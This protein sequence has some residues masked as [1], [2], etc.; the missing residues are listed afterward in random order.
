MAIPQL[1]GSTST[2]A[3]PQ[4]FKMLLRNFNSAIPQSQLILKSATLN[5]QLESFTSVIFGIFLAR[6]SS[7]FK[8]KIEVRK[9]CATVPL[10]KFFV[11]QRN[12]QF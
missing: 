9:F 7:Q 1:E 12:R 10:R 2:I 5:P 6:E 3:I 11:F 4:L 8:K